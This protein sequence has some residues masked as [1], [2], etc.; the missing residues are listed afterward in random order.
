MGRALEKRPD[1]GH[2]WGGRREGERVTRKRV[3]TEGQRRGER[4]GREGK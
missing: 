2:R 1:G 3:P 4:G